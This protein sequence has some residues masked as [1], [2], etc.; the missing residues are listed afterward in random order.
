[1]RR[2]VGEERRG[3]EDER[4]SRGGGDEEK[5]RGRDGRR[6]AEEQRTS[7]GEE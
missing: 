2:G 4:E 5:N 3:G 6:E 1:M 7:R